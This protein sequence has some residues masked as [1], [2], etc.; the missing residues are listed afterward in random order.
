MLERDN[1]ALRAEIDELRGSTS[2]LMTAPLRSLS[3]KLRPVKR[4]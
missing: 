2:W 3:R 4:R 1:R